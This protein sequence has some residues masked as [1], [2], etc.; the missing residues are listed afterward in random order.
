MS[1]TAGRTICSR[2]GSIRSST[3]AIRWRSWRGRL[4]GGFWKSG[5]APVYSD[6]SGQPPLPTRLTA[7]IVDTTVQPKAV[8]FPIDAKLMH[9]KRERLIRLAKKHGVTLRQSASPL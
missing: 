6:G 5:S 7:V 2:R 1:G 3:L 4:T 8:A 9:R